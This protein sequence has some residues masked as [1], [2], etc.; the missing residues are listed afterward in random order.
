MLHRNTWL[1]IVVFMMAL[2]LPPALGQARVNQD[3]TAASVWARKL[4]EHSAVNASH[5]AVYLLPQRYEHALCFAVVG[6]SI[7]GFMYCRC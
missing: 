2:A 7:A 3:P 4:G 5:T 1:V 6:E